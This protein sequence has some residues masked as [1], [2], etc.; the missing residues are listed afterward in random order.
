MEFTRFN[1][2]PHSFPKPRAPLLP[3]KPAL[4]WRKVVSVAAPQ[5]KTF[6]HFSRGRYALAQAYRL[7]GVG[8]SGD[9][10]A[11]AYHCVT[12]LDPALSLDAN[13]R[14]YPLRPD[15]TPDLAALEQLL[16][17]PGNTVKG[18]L[19]T[20][21]FGFVQDFGPLKKWCNSHDITLIEDCSH[22]L[23]T[24]KFQASG[25]GRSGYF[26]CSS[27]YKFFACEDGGLLHCQDEAL[28]QGVTTSTPG[29]LDELRAIKHG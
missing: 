10:L 24:E 29:L 13:V 11:P 27:P 28:L 12:M 5:S 3:F 15:L 1:P 9:L 25:A 20:H 7:A 2:Q 21:F 22:I 8:T 18:L 16:K 23:Y 6:K 19:A 14:L 26:V 4:D 17:Q